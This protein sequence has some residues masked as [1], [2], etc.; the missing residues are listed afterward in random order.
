MENTMTEAQRYS[1]LVTGARVRRSHTL[2]EMCGERDQVDRSGSA[3]HEA[4]GTPSARMS[5][6]GD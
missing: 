3:G 1:G 4:N 6:K 5:E 2:E